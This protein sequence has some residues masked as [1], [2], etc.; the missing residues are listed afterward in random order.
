MCGSTLSVSRS[1][2]SICVQRGLKTQG[3][4]KVVCGRQNSPG[5]CSLLTRPV[6]PV[7]SLGSRIV[8]KPWRLSCSR[9]AKF[10]PQNLR[11]THIRLQI[12]PGV[13]YTAE[14]GQPVVRD[15]WKGAGQASVTPA[16]SKPDQGAVGSKGKSPSA[17][18]ST[19]PPKNT[20]LPLRKAEDLQWHPGLPPRAHKSRSDVGKPVYFHGEVHPVSDDDDTTEASPTTSDIEETVVTSIAGRV[21]LSLLSSQL[22]D[23]TR[24]VIRFHGR[25]STA[26]L[27]ETARQFK[28]LHIQDLVSSPGSSSSLTTNEVVASTRRPQFWKSPAVRTRPSSAATLIS[29]TC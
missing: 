2:R 29:D 15:S 25:S 24:N 21:K 28:N 20:P 11:L 17:R 10:Q 1:S 5:H 26:G 19:F 14:L 23:S 6:N 4:P 7:T 3:T 9:S 16:S 27:V 12:S 8:S 18:D 13:D 22:D